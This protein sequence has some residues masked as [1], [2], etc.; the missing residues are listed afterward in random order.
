MNEL[1][2]YPHG[3]ELDFLQSQVI[4]KCDADDGIVDGIIMDPDACDFDP[5]EV[6]GTVFYCNETR[7]DREVT[8]AAAQV[9]S[10]YH[11]G[12]RGPD[13]EF[14]W[15]G[16]HWGANLTQT[17]FG[18]P[19]LAATACEGETCT[20][21]PFPFG[22]FWMRYFALK[23]PTWSLSSMTSREYARVFRLAAKE[24]ASIYN[25]V[26]P[27]L[28]MFRD[29]GRKMITYHG[30]V[31]DLDPVYVPRYICC[32][33]LTRWLHLSPMTSRHRKAQNITT[34]RF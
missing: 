19:G 17:I 20:G 29:A 25:T 15:H 28:S 33:R 6:V 26:D 4:N 30:L 23:D 16:P 9:A 2:E 1:G 3:C 32:A 24:F 34:G 27:D 5:F 11:A 31:R 7:S 12:A 21:K 8:L 18:T 14:L 22:V 10:A 13:G